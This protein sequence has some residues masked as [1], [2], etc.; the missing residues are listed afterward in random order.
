[1]QVTFWGTR[2]T[3]PVPGPDTVRY[4]GNS[5]CVSVLTAAGE[6]LILDA[7]TGI[8]NLGKHL[9]EPGAPKCATLF[10][11]HS[12]WDHIQG[13]PLFGPLYDS[14]FALTVLGC[15]S[16][17]T[18]LHEILARQQDSPVFP[19]PLDA[20]RAEIEIG[21]YCMEW[22]I[23]GSVRIRTVPLIHP[24]GACGFRIEEAGRALVFM[25]DNELPAKGPVWD[26]F[27]SYCEG[28][29]LLIH[30]AQYTDE[31]LAAH[32]G[33]GHSSISQA[34]DLALD[35]R[36]KR[37]ALFHH[38]PD[39]TDD[40]LDALVASYRQAIAARGTGMAL[41]GAAEGVTETV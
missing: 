25:T 2:G 17:R 5:T 20:L 7:G 26:R 13:F 11:S 8:R 38:D 14:A 16:Y 31:E 15:A 6:L 10:L 36:V 40:G 18:D 29:D 34:I 39:R 23:V 33:W 4:G 22:A 3:V 24:G 37:L 41:F 28:A 30:D 1:M 21:D 9:A 35:A 19:V 32:R 27:V 12:H